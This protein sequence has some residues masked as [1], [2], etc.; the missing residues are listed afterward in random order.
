VKYFIFFL[1]FTCSQKNNLSDEDQV[2]QESIELSQNIMDATV[3]ELKI[4]VYFETLAEP[5]VG[6]F[7]FGTDVWEV[8]NT[9]V[10]ELFARFESRLITTPY[11]IS[12]MTEIP[13]NSI[14]S[15]NSDQL[16][17]LGESIAPSLKTNNKINTSVIY[18]NGVYNGNSNILGLHF[19]GR[20]FVFIFKDVIESVGGTND[21]QKYV[22]QSVV[23]HELGHL[24]G[25]VNSGIA[26]ATNHEDANH[27]HHTIND[28]CVMYW[29]VE[30]GQGALDFAASVLLDRKL[31]LYE[32]E[33]QNDVNQY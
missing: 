28:E 14:E 18:V 23:V 1:L 25:L 7:L 22:E 30:R 15:W 24:F 10:T 26:Q 2:D 31:N 32:Q 13:N 29:A 9:S 17:A 33:V 6:S 19:S 16:L 4:N 21:Q 11:E 5:Y 3:N 27:P 20:R 12:E 8:T